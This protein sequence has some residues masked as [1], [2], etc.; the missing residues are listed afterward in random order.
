MKKKIWKKTLQTSTAVL[1]T[2]DIFVASLVLPSSTAISTYKMANIKNINNENKT[3]VTMISSGASVLL[4]SITGLG[5]VASSA[6]PSSS[7]RLI[8][9][10]IATQNSVLIG[11]S[12]YGVKL[13]THKSPGD[14]G[15]FISRFEQYC[16][17]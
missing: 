15:T 12:T 7:L 13:P 5:A 8:N 1:A 17:L 2:S 3:A 16:I 10:A 11:N 6:V 14:I 9:V 4:S